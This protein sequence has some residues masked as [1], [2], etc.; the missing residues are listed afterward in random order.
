MP[1][2]HQMTKALPTRLADGMQAIALVAQQTRT[3]AG[4]ADTSRPG[5]R[6][7]DLVTIKGSPVVTPEQ[8]WWRVGRQGE[9]G[10]A[11]V[12]E[13]DANTYYLEPR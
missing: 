5:L 2:T 6:Q 7:G 4:G 8:R 13:C 9:K 10:V 11:W 1:H 3:S 12:C